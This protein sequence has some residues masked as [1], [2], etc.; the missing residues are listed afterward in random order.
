MLRR[1]EVERVE[2]LSWHVTEQD[3]QVNFAIWQ[4]SLQF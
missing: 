4:R 1:L 2:E 3:F